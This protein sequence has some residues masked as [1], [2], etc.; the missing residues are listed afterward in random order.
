MARLSLERTK[1]LFISNIIEIDRNLLFKCIY[2]NLS[3]LLFFV[4]STIGYKFLLG[5]IIDNF[6]FS[7]SFFF[8]FSC[9]LIFFLYVF[10]F[11]FIS[12]LHCFHFF[13]WFVKSFCL[14]FFP[15]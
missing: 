12:S 8:S 5:S 14:S 9:V 13:L 6:V 10:N 3:R 2:F 1:C 7:Q 4:H 15:L 11:V